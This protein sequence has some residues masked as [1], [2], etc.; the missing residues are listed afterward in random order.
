M[1]VAALYEI[2]IRKNT[3]PIRVIIDAS[4]EEKDRRKKSKWYRA[5]AYAAEKQVPESRFIAFLNK[6]GGVA[7]CVAKIAALEK[8]RAKDKTARW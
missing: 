2:G 1:Q 5:V 6:K 4:S 8:E 7:G 3:K